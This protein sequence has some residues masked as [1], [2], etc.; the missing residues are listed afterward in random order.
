MNRNEEEITKD[1]TNNSSIVEVGDF[2]I[3][4]GGE[5]ITLLE[6][7]KETYKLKIKSVDEF[8]SNVKLSINNQVKGITIDFDKLQYHIPKNKEVEIIMILENYDRYGLGLHNITLVAESNYNKHAIVK[9]ID[10]IA[11]GDVI[12]E[13]EGYEFHPNILTV[14]KGAS[15]TWINK[16]DVIHTVTE[17][18]LDFRSGNIGSQS[19]FRQKFLEL[20][21]YSYYCEPHTYMLGKIR[22]IE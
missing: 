13:I 3:I 14:K 11:K 21:T 22:V 4:D 9:T 20:G 18:E 12:I 2:M 16:D 15:I 10:V 1:S 8:E 6:S 7:E 19:A 17:T 5:T